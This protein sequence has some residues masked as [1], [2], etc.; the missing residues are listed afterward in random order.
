MQ[1]PS[2]NAPAPGTR[3]C[4]LAEVPDGGGHAVVFGQG[5]DAFDLLLL[6]RG[7]AVFGY[8]NR[9]PHQGLPLD[10]A[11]DQFL[12]E[13]GQRVVCG[14]HNATFSLDDGRCLGGPCTG[15]LEPFAV[16][17]EGDAVVAG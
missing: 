11:A 7:Q 16:R 15:G 9:C 4:A 2:P 8:L 6:R 10:V 5:R 17:V 14:H 1:R 12:V 3:V 13:E